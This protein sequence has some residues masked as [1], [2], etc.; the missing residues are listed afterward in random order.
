MSGGLESRAEGKEVDRYLFVIT[1]G[2]MGKKVQG[3]MKAQ[4]EIIMQ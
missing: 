4:R 1:N 2:M 3:N